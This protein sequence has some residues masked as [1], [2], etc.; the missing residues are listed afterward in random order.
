MCLSTPVT[1]GTNAF[2]LSH[3]H[4]GYTH[5]SVITLFVCQAVKVLLSSCLTYQPMLAPPC[6]V[7]ITVLESS[8]KFQ[9]KRTCN[10]VRKCVLV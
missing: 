3:L 1:N 6:N 7:H 9:E 5:T 2:L 8:G 4:P 10:N